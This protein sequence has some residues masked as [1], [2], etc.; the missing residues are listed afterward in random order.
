MDPQRYR[1]IDI[2]SRAE[3]VRNFHKHTLEAVA[4]LLGAAGIRH[5]KDLNR[6][7]IVR[8]LSAS[9]IKL[10]DQIY[11][12]VSDGALLT[13][14]G[15]IEDRVSEH[16]GRLFQKILFT[17]LM[18]KQLLLNWISWPSTGRFDTIASLPTEGVVYSLIKP[19]LF[20][21]NPELAHDLTINSLKALGQCLGPL[22]S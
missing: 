17:W 8:R 14:E 10:A 12:R 4:E 1:A 9:Q 3:R 15:V 7:H 5:P 11:P 6:R 16:I 13:G 20:R 21:I 18:S 2:P 22:S 19:A